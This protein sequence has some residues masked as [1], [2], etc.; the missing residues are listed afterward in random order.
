MNEE[1]GDAIKQA[2]ESGDA[3][4]AVVLTESGDEIVPRIVTGPDD[5]ALESAYAGDRRYPMASF[6]I[7]LLPGLE[8]RLAVPVRECDRRML[9]E[10]HKHNQVD[11]SRLV[12]L[13]VPCSQEVADTCGCDHPFTPADIA[14]A[15]SLAHPAEP[16]PPPESLAEDPSERLA[17]WLDSFSR[18]IKCMGCRNICPMCYCKECALDD[19]NL[20][21]Q[22]SGPPDTPIF[23][24]IRAIDMADRCVDCGM[25]EAICPSEIPLRQ[26]YRMA[27]L[28]VEEAFGY[29]PGLDPD[30]VSPIKMLGGPEDLGGMEGGSRAD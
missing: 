22:G 2:L 27:R 12:L 25:C 7:L 23:H 19:P 18:C 3:S 26:L 9:T 1:L 29:Q 20:V 6:A 5:P 21:G 24:L 4:A 13:G 28:V 30:Q 15:G 10:L 17:F 11:T 16:S 8:G 14:I